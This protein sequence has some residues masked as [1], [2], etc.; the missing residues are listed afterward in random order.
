MNKEYAPTAASITLSDGPY[1]NPR[2]AVVLPYKS[3]TSDTS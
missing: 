1:E 2:D 3:A